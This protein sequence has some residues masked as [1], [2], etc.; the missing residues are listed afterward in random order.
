MKKL[1]LSSIASLALFSSV[2]NATEAQSIGLT[3]G[4]T[5]VEL[6][7]SRMINSDYNLAIRIMGGGLTYS[8]TYDDTDANYDT[9]VDLLNFGATLEY[10]PFGNGF[11]LGV[12]AFYNGNS[13]DMV[14]TPKADG[15]YEFGGNEYSVADVG[16]VDGEVVD[17]NN[18]APYLGIGY[19][20]SLFDDGSWF[21]NFKAGAWY[22]DSPKVELRSSNCT[23]NAEL[24]RAGVNTCDNLR[25]D[26]Q[27][28]ENDINED[29]KD[30]KWWPV[31]HIGV[32][33][34][35]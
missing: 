31:L 30:Y 15:T 26:L 14:A 4:T 20:A 28:E 7:Y 25:E 22:Q 17:L 27:K 2:L 21:F 18:L 19:D 3:A 24:L 6:E 12:G 10:H 5:G 8:G 32:T 11:Y 16:T 1:L 34:R 9:D 13:F 23:P 29:I 33:Y 35:F